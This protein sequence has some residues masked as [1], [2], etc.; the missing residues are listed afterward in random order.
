MLRDRCCLTRLQ[1]SK[2]SLL[3]LPLMESLSYIISLIQQNVS[4]INYNW[5]YGPQGRLQRFQIGKQVLKY[6][7]KYIYPSTNT[8]KLGA[9][10]WV[11]KKVLLPWYVGSIFVEEV[12]LNCVIQEYI[13]C[14]ALFTWTRI[15][16]NW[17]L[18][19]AY[20]Q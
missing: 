19:S 10:P 7:F 5:Q 4:G 8:G 16:N 13:L 1:L 6:L 20:T 9:M 15:T 3:T 2:T 12:K 17:T 11:Q 18:L 14:C